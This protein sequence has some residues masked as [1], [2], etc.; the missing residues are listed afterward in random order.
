MFIFSV[1]QVLSSEENYNCIW[2][3][4]VDDLSEVSGVFCIQPWTSLLLT[5]HKHMRTEEN[6]G[7]LIIKLNDNVENF[8]FFINGSRYLIGNTEYMIKQYVQPI[9]YSNIE[10]NLFSLTLLSY[11][12][13]F[14][15][16]I[17]IPM[18]SVM[19]IQ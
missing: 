19:R 2:Q 6:E 17:Y 11:E 3:N 9:W 18:L 16:G 4:L 15:R 8:D 1:F 13:E 12:I 7:L 5:F 10:E 14:K